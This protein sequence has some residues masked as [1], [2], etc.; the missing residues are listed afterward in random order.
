MTSTKNGDG[1]VTRLWI[2]LFLN[3]RFTVHGCGEVGGGV[4]KIVIFC[5]RHKC[6]TLKNFTGIYFHASCNDYLL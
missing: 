2:L 5:K 6:M 3:N 1:D 4:K